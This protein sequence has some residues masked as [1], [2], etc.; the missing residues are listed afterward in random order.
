MRK[1]IT[2]GNVLLASRLL[3]WSKVRRNHRT[4]KCGR[5]HSVAAEIE[6]A[7]S[8]WDVCRIAVSELRTGWQLMHGIWPRLI[9]ALASGKTQAFPQ[10]ILLLLIGQGCALSPKVSTLTAAD[11]PMALTPAA[12]IQPQVFTNTLHIL[13]ATNVNWCFIIQ[14]CT[15]LNAGVWK[16][17]VIFNNTNVPASWTDT[18]NL[19]SAVYRPVIA[20]LK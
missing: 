17:V 7:P 15:N 16:D 14:R 19:P 1:R 12:T 13:D 3:R 11:K 20:P 2:N 6:A 9:N 4:P 5:V 18:N 8:S 10:S